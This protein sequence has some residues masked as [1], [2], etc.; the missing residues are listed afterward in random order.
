[1]TPSIENLAR[2]LPVTL[3]AHTVHGTAA[4]AGDADYLYIQGRQD[5]L[6][7]FWLYEAGKEEQARPASEVPCNW[8]WLVIETA[9][10]D[11][12][13]LDLAASTNAGIL[14]LQATELTRA[15]NAPPRPGIHMKR[16]PEL[17]SEWKQMSD[18]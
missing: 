3:P 8:F 5:R 10:P 17:R 11:K 1:M 18:F 16:H 14:V 12:G 15:L 7:G 4:H 13:V 2:L 6:H 9:T